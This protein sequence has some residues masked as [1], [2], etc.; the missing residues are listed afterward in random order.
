MGRKASSSKDVIARGCRQA[1]RLANDPNRLAATSCEQLGVAAAFLAR[2]LGGTDES[3]TT[4]D[5][6]S[7]DALRKFEVA[8][9]A[10]GAELRRRQAETAFPRT[11]F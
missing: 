2:A 5:A 7:T 1:V 11:R 9:R 6:R 3:S 4:M 10:I 8:C